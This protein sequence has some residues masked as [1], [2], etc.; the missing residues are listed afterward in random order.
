MRFNGGTFLNALGRTFGGYGQDQEDIRQRERQQGLDRQNAQSFAMQQQAHNEASQLNGL[1]MRNY[2]SEIDARDSAGRRDETSRR[3]LEADYQAANAGDKQAQARIVAVRPD[4]A[5]DFMPKA[6]PKPATIHT[7]SQ[8]NMQTGDIE[9]VYDD[10]HRVVVRKATPAEIAKASHVPANPADANEEQRKFLRTQALQGDY[11]GNETVK[12]AYGISNAVS[13]LKAALAGETPMDDLSIIYETVK[14]FDPGSA[15]KEGE[16]K[17]AQSANSLPGQVQLLVDGWRSGRKLTPAMRQQIAGLLERKVSESRN[18]VAPVQSEA[19]AM[20]RRYGVA[21][22]S[23]YIAPDPFR[24]VAGPPQ[25][26]GGANPD[27]RPGNITL[28]GQPARLTP[29]QTLRAAKDS[30]YA[31]FLRSKG[32]LR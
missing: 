2:Q 19:G 22:D 1:Q 24:G 14:L 15:V 26:T 21:P 13:G 23:A 29:E 31:A 4:L 32:L 25:G 9:D 7:P 28:G 17:L 3:V 11:K 27:S 30:T 16:I 5:N 6:P 18:A 20:A 8:L 12:K 10:G